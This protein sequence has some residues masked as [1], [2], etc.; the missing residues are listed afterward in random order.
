M[1][2]KRDPKANASLHGLRELGVPSSSPL[3]LDKR[4]HTLSACT[5]AEPRAIRLAVA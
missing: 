2:A 4:Q 5:A 3:G 1:I